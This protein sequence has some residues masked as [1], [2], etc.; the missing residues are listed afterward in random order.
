MPV[1]M[2]RSQ[3]DDGCPCACATKTT[4]CPSGDTANC[5]VRP[6]KNVPRAASIAGAWPVICATSDREKQRRDDARDIGEVGL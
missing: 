3:S 5:G 2:A 6:K 4:D 1:A